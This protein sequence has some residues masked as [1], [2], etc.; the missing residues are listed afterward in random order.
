MVPQ[1]ILPTE[2]VF[3]PSITILD[4]AVIQYTVFIMNL[5]DMTTQRLDVA[6]TVSTKVVWV[7]GL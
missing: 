4:V 3:P 2:P 7:I 1:V 5:T 6:T